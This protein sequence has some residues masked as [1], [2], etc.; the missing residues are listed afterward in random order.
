METAQKFEVMLDKFNAGDAS[1]ELFQKILIVLLNNIVAC[2]LLARW[3]S[4]LFF[5]PEDGGDTVLRNVGCNSTN[6]TATY[7]RRRYSSI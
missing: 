2:H 1:N 4:E 6:Y 5:D 7:P 3:F